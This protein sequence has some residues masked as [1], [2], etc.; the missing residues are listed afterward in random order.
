MME[1]LLEPNRKCEIHNEKFTL[2]CTNCEQF[3]CLSCVEEHSEKGHVMRKLEKAF[4][5]IAVKC[6]ASEE[7][8]K[9]RK[10][11]LDKQ[12]KVRKDMKKA[13]DTNGER[14]VK[15]LLDLFA[16]VDALVAAAKRE[17]LRRAVLDADLQLRKCRSEPT[18]AAVRRI[19]SELATFPQVLAH[20]DPLI[21]FGLWQSAE[22]L[23]ENTAGGLRTN[24]TQQPHR[25]QVRPF[26]ESLVD[27]LLHV[28]TRGEQADR[29][30]IAA[31]IPTSGYSCTP[32]IARN[33]R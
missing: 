9:Q 29:Q 19:Q 32:H 16:R 8:L 5:L 10:Q 26:L 28:Q 33:S 7:K 18:I 15:E 25:D 30:A 1:T 4:P 11:T 21:A 31:V 12:L 23:L 24:K 20:Q 13:A 17:A 2:F 6:R 3:V 27:S 22:Q 14:A